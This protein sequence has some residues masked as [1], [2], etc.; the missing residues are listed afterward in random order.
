MNPEKIGR[1][2]VQALEVSAALFFVIGLPFLSR[3]TPY[4][5]GP[6]DL[7]DPTTDPSRKA[8]YVP[9]APAKKTVTIWIRAICVYGV[10]LVIS[11]VGVGIYYLIKY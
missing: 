4:I 2:L 10:L 6:R 3:W 11:L 7:Y 8:N 9:K 1:F 5:P